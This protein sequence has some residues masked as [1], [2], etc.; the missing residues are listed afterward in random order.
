MRT[1]NSIWGKKIGAYRHPGDP[2][3]LLMG[4]THSLHPGMEKKEGGMGPGA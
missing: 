3:D 1:G 4:I 2:T